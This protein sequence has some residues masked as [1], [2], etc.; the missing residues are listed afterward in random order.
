MAF[1]SPIV[2]RW[3]Q[4]IINVNE[5]AAIGSVL[6][7]IKPVPSGPLVAAQHPP[8]TPSLS[9]TSSPGSADA[10]LGRLSVAHKNV[11]QYA[12]NH[13]ERQVPT[14][15]GAI[16][17]FRAD[18][19]TKKFNPLFRQMRQLDDSYAFL[20]HVCDDEHY[21]EQILSDVSKMIQEYRTQNASL[22]GKCKTSEPTDA[23]FQAFHPDH[24]E[25]DPSDP[26]DQEGSHRGTAAQ[27]HADLEG[28]LLAGQASQDC[29]LSA[30]VFTLIY[31]FNDCCPNKFLDPSEVARVAVGLQDEQVC[32]TINQ[33]HSRHHKIHNVT[34]YVC[35]S[36]RK[37][38]FG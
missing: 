37:I 35:A 5:I 38:R 21:L 25:G 16:G 11:L 12:T 30:K 3:G 6:E 33:A 17:G 32:N 27:T 9:S 8:D 10:L 19:A 13:L 31:E 22:D 18:D 29:A 26:R 7:C 23:T 24:D 1:R 34:A 2:I 4:A 15:H 14:M 36:L 20:R 28:S